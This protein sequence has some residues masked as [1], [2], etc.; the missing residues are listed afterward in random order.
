MPTNPRKS[1]KAKAA[2]AGAAEAR[3]QKAAKAARRLNNSCF[4][5]TVGGVARTSAPFALSGS[6]EP[7][8]GRSSVG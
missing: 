5:L 7:L 1:R 3:P 4:C 2:M 8:R 6:P